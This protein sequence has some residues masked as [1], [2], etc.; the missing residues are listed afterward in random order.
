MAEDASP[1]TPTIDNLLEETVRLVTNAQHVIACIE[2]GVDIVDDDLTR[3]EAVQDCTRITA[4]LTAVM[5][6]LLARKALANGEFGPDDGRPTDRLFGVGDPR[7][8]PALIDAGRPDVDAL[9]SL[10]GE[11]GKLFERIARLDRMRDRSPAKEAE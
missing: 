9:A 2:G 1:P 5:S 4:R 3:L 8:D 6:W 7:V 11:T 10:M